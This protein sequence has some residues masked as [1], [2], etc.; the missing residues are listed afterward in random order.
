MAVLIALGAGVVAWRARPPAPPPDL[1]VVEVRGEVPSPGFYALSAP[2][3]VGDAVRAAGGVSE[4]ATPVEQ[5]QAV[6]VSGGAAE[7]GPSDAALTLGRR[8]DLNAA[9]QAALESLPG[10]GP[11]RAAAIVADRQ[12]HGPFSDV[13]ALDR[14]KGFGPATVERL[15][16]YLEVGATPPAR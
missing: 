3:T 12:A 11:S 13:D 9:S 10:V 16:P 5:G 6:V 15:R 2:V 1:S 8:L 14:V 7:V 4:V